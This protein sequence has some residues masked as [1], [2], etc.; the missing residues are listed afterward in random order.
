MRIIAGGLIVLC[1]VPSAARGAA[2]ADAEAGRAKVAVVCAA[3]H[4]AAGISVSETIPNLAGQRAGYIQAQ[5][6]ALKDGSRKNPIMNAIAGQLSDAE[7][8]N[9]AAYFSS[10]TIAVAGAK[11]DFLPNLAHTSVTFPAD[12]KSTFTSYHAINNTTARRVQYFYANP[13]A[14]QAARE[15]KSLPDGSVL[16]TE[17]WSAKLDAQGNSVM[18]EGGLYAPDQVL[19]YA[20][21]ARAAGWGRDIPDMLRNEDWNY[22]AFTPA[23]ELRAGINQAECLACHKPLDKASFTFSLDPLRVAARKQ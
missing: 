16:L 7:I 12:F 2:A 1:L 17:T 4:G 6:R 21:M 15:G 23:H 5:L 3:C 9:V 13:T 20:A 14:L 18:G 22:A 19:G 10:Q 8:A 11:S